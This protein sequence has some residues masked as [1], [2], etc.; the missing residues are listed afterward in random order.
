MQIRYYTKKGSIYIYQTDTSG[1]GSWLKQDRNGLFLPL[2]GAIHLLRTR[3]QELVREY[4]TSALDTT[5]CF[6]N[7]VAKEF[8]DDARREHI[9]DIP[10]GQETN[11]FFLLSK[12]KDKY[13]LG[14]SSVVRRIEKIE[15][16]DEAKKNTNRFAM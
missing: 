5:V 2:A 13:T 11:I 10:A 6:G 14:Y 16:V 9:G 3:L 4:P 15:T 8:F 12:G 7:G 1:N